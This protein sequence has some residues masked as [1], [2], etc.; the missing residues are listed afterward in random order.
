LQE[1]GIE[2]FI[3]HVT[4]MDQIMVY[5]ILSTQGLMINED[6]KSSGR[7]PRKEQIVAWIKEAQ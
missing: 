2:A 7:L 5:P 4:E 6:V 1:A 3:D